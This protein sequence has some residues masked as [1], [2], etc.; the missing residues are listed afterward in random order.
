M[1][2]VLLSFSALMLAFAFH[3]CTQ[4]PMDPA[5]VQAKVDSMAASKIE[6]ASA[7]AIS[8][9]ETRM[10]TELKSTT[11]SLVHAAQMANAAQ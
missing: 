11:D 4:A 5:A 9:C 2:K 3:S 7:A 1:K 10:A 6:A 8:E